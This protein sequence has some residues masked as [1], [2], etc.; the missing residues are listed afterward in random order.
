MAEMLLVIDSTHSLTSELQ[1]ALEKIPDREVRVLRARSVHEALA[2]LDYGWVDLVICS[3][4]AEGLDG[5][6]LVPQLRRR[7]PRIAIAFAADGD[8]G[9]LA[10]SAMQRGV[11]EVLSRPVDSA[12]LRLLLERTSHHQRERRTHGLLRRELRRALG[13]RPIVAAS[14]KMI[15]VLEGVE[16]AAGA[17]TPVL[18]I[19]ELGTGKESI[20]RAIHA[21]SARNSSP[22]VALPCSAVEPSYIES[23]LF[24]RARGEFAEAAPARRGLLAE[25]RGGTLFLDEIGGLTPALQTR[26]ATSILE[27]AITVGNDGQRVDIDV[28]L[29]ASTQ[30]DLEREAKAGRFSSELMGL[31]EIPPISVPPL[32]ERREDIP[33]LADHF[34]RLI[35]GRHGKSVRSLSD[36]ALDLVTNYAWPG[37]IR[38]LENTLERAVLLAS[39]EKL[40]RRDLPDALQSADV[41]TDDDVWALRPAKRAAETAAIRRALRATGGNRTHAAK[42][43][44][45]SQR[46]LLYK[47]KEY[48]I[49][50]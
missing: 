7:L 12:T 45:I 37:N 28:H 17:Q 25:A 3:P 19:G 43:L 15:H 27:G 5:Y 40:E 44:R 10:E 30:R 42:R 39:G 20:A 8:P 1:T 4:T 31:F 32:R 2:H 11:R 47:L 16:R 26:L 48:G 34:L 6:D 23:E 18:I 36:D 14:R 29:V 21:Q 33:L 24:G 50:D 13:E 38:E 41:E 49:R 22:F 35:N 9:E 46:A